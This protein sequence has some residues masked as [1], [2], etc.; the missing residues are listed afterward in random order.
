VT[1]ATKSQ[2][3]NEQHCHP[4]RADRRSEGSLREHNEKAL[5]SWANVRDLNGYQRD[6]SLRAAHSV[7]N[8]N[9]KQR[10]AL[11][12]RTYVR[13]LNGYQRDSSLRAAHSVRNDNDKQRTALSSWTSRQAKWRISL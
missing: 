10:T 8:D 3:R 13:D 9:D 5:S 2:E 6:S 12:S 11:S 4:E 1:E 7:R